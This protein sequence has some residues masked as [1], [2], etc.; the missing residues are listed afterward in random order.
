MSLNMDLI[1][2]LRERQ[3]DN[4][5]PGFNALTAVWSGKTL[6]VCAGDQRLMKSLGIAG[7]GIESNCILVIILDDIV[8]GFQTSA[9]L[10]GK[11]PVSQQKLVYQGT[12]YRVLDTAIPAGLAFIAVALVDP[13]K[14]I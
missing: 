1:Q 3:F 13:N 10:T 14:G 7:F 6:P 11:I 2:A 4:L 5:D 12:Q 9:D 8:P